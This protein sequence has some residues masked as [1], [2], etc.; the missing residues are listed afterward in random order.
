[1]VAVIMAGRA[2][3]AFA[4]EIGTM[5][6]SEEIEA[7]TTMG[8]STSRFLIVPKVLG[9]VTVMPLIT[10]FANIMGAIGGIFIA[11]INLGM[12]IPSAYNRLI[13]AI[14]PM[15]ITQGLV[16]ALVFAFIVSS[17]GCMRG[18]QAESNARGVGEAT[19]SA[20]V[21]GIFLIIIADFVLTA[22]FCM[23]NFQ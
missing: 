20:V 11:Y 6:V 22:L 14:T 19:T 21:T 13:T 5:K 7:L 4:A 3:S 15:G 16:K 10:I 8:F 23:P 12:A 18:I 9:L 2:G 1:M 17:I